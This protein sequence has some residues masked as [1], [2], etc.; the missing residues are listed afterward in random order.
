MSR[1]RSLLPSLQS[2]VAFEAAARNLSFKLAAGELN[3]T[4]PSISHAIKTLER[5]CQTTL[6]IRE[7]R[8]VRLTDSG[9]VLFEGVRA[10]FSRIEESLETIVDRDATYLTLAVSTSLAANWLMPQLYDF[11]R[12]FPDTRLRV[13]TTDRDVE[14]NANL[15]MTIWVRS[16]KW[17]RPNVR[18]LCD[19]VVFPIC[20]AQYLRTHPPLDE[21]SDL[22]RHKLI[23]AFDVYRDRLGWKEWLR[24]AEA[25]FAEP[26]PDF[27]FNDYQLAIQAA[28]AGEG[29]SLGWSISA[30]LLIR[31]KVLVRPIP[32]EVRT[33]SAFFFVANRYFSEDD[34]IGKF[35][36]WLLDKTRHLR[37]AP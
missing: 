2:L 31:D 17:Q 21:L 9:R 19:E 22:S 12:R 27:V 3:V 24:L 15:D 18:F 28:L 26:S 37:Q 30:E 36:H 5:R 16:R 29:V 32:D 35:S 33:G 11:Q 20:T 34:H 13:L 4:Q 23:H 25:S 7:N 14:P 6:F 10:G 8:G 1:L